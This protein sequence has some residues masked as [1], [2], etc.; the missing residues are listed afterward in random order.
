[1]VCRSLVYTLRVEAGLLGEVG[2]APYIERQQR[3]GAGT[4]GVGFIATMMDQLSRGLLAPDPVPLL[5]RRR[6]GQRK[7]DLRSFVAMARIKGVRAEK[8]P[9]ASDLLAGYGPA[10]ADQFAPA[11]VL[12]EVGADVAHRICLVPGQRWRGTGQRTDHCL[13]E[14]RGI[15]CRLSQPSQYGQSAGFDGARLRRR[16]P[17]GEDGGE[18]GCRQRAEQASGLGE[19]V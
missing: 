12:Q 6:A 3:A 4:H 17:S 18:F 19:E 13:A 11:V 15:G 16:R 1:M 10:R 5:P 7:V 9:S 8:Q 2:A 14:T